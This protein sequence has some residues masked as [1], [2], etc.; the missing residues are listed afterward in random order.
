MSLTATRLLDLVLAENVAIDTD[1]EETPAQ[2]V[3]R[4]LS[5]PRTPSKFHTG[6]ER[7][8]SRARD[9]HGSY[10]WEYDGDGNVDTGD[11]VGDTRIAYDQDDKQQIVNVE[12]ERSD[13]FATQ[14]EAMTYAARF[15][16]D[17]RDVTND[18]AYEV[19]YEDSSLWGTQFT[20]TFDQWKRAKERLTTDDE[21]YVLPNVRL[22]HP[23]GTR[24][25]S[26]EDSH[27]LVN[28]Q[29]KV[30][31]IKTTSLSECSRSHCRNRKAGHKHREV[32]DTLVN[33]G[34]PG[35]NHVAACECGWKVVEPRT[36]TDESERTVSL[37][38]YLHLR[39]HQPN[40]A[41]YDPRYRSLNYVERV[42]SDG[43]TERV[44]LAYDNSN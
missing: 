37:A 43:T 3:A 39:T 16:A 18:F 8:V 31:L 36:V 35:V 30:A 26:D 5:E 28:W 4:I 29:R 17:E 41:L 23:H 32:T 9:A 38:V 40:L 19:D 20:Q 15:D 12:S 13:G 44:P 21:Q 10:S 1:T 6:T 34:A 27:G 11:M 22:T 25:D 24:D 42:L 14:Q 7:A 2:M 33:T